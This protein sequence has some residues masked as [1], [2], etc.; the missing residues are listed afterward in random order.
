[1]LD[2]SQRSTRA[3]TTTADLLALGHLPHARPSRNC[4]GTTWNRCGVAWNSVA[5][6]DRRGRM[7]SV[8]WLARR[9]NRPASSQFGCEILGAIYGGDLH[10]GDD[11]ARP[12]AFGPG[13]LVHIGGR[14]MLGDSGRQDGRTSGR[15]S[16]HCA[17]RSAY[18]S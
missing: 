10:T 16:C 12:S 3:I 2:Y 15:L 5:A 9:G 6:H 17:W 18:A 11:G 13:G 1:M 14:N 4:D 8:W 7:A